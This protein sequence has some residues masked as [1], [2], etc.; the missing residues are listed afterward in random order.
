MNI[1]AQ[2]AEALDAAHARGL[3]HRDIK[4][5]NILIAPG[6]RTYLTDFGLTK[7]AES[8]SGLTKTGTWVG[9]ADY[10]APE[11]VQGQHVDARTDVYAL[12]CVLFEALTGQ[13]PFPR[14]TEIAKIYA[15]MQ[16]EPPAVDWAALGVPVAMGDVVRRAMAKDPAAR[17]QSAGDLGRAARAAVA[18]RPVSEPERTVAV[19][20]AAA[21]PQPTVIG[22]TP[23]A[24]PSPTA[25]GATQA[26][27][28]QA[29]PPQ[30]PP[31]YGTPPYGTP[32]PERRRSRTPL[33]VLGVIL[34]LA[35]AGVGIAAAT[36]AF[37]TSTNTV[38]TQVTSGGTTGATT[39]QDTGATTTAG[40]V[41]ESDA[42]D[43][44]RRYANAY[45]A[46]DMNAL[47]SMFAPNFVRRAPPKADMNRSAALREYKR[48]FAN[49]TNPN[50]SLS[51]ENIQT[52]PNGATATADYEITAD[53][54]TPA[55]GSIAFSI[56]SDN[57]T[58]LIDAI[59][60]R[61]G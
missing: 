21:G 60:I 26:L 5:G 47:D 22:Y 13:L 33:I 49:L 28:P 56:V 37:N 31:Q 2:V 50:Y 25:T 41:S 54:A 42:R 23:A 36:G 53:N 58:L 51:N 44:L 18:D 3:V 15:H 45:S 17:F 39:G 19:G 35:G 57:G 9:T 10:V 6:D 16:E 8:S 1:V 11:Q 34:L 55:S 40:S 27:P 24:A 59:N 43:I 52:G 7:H 20:A 29:P 4:P 38:T 12:G 32:P 14:P 48:Q 46:E 30:G 61:S